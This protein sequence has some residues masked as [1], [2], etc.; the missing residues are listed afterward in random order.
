[1]KRFILFLIVAGLGQFG[2]LKVSG[3]NIIGNPEPDEKELS[4]LPFLEKKESFS[5]LI[6]NGK[7]WIMLAGELHNSSSSNI[8]NLE[9]I[10]DKMVSMNLNTVI[11][12]VSWELFEPVE[13]AFNYTLV[14]SII[15]KARE[16][17][18]KLVLI[19][20]GTWKNT[21]STYAPEWVKHDM[22]RFPRMQIIQG[23]NT[24][25]L[26]AFGENT[27]KADAAAFSAL[28]NHIREF[29]AKNQTVLMMQVENE[30]GVLGTTRDKS[31]LADSWFNKNIPEELSTYLK[32]NEK[33]L[34]PEIK[35]MVSSN[36]KLSGS[37]HEVFGY[38][39]D[40]V[41]QAWFT[42]RYVQKV[43]ESGKAA[44]NIPMYAN[45]WLDPDFS[46]SLKPNYPSGGPVMKVLDIWRAAAPD[47]DFLA[48][49]IYLDDFKRVCKM[50]AEAGNPLFIP[51][52]Q[53]DCRAAANVYYALGQHNAI[54]FSPFGI[55]GIENI[56]PV[57]DAYGSLKAL[58]PFFAE[59]QGVNK[60]IGLLYSG[61]KKEEFV[62]GGYK[63]IITYNQVRDI[64]KNQPEAAGLI[65]NTIEGEFFIAGFGFR[66]DFEQPEKK[67]WVEY[68]MHEEG[69]FKNGVW[70]PQRRMNGDELELILPS[71]PSVRKVKVHVVQ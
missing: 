42:A 36:K 55:D 20:F 48:P 64:E 31:V 4:V 13:G 70:K 51:E 39:A 54:C 1:M 68:L 53:R 60:N 18:L 25:A 17:N 32:K 15:L 52:A 16:H 47:I 33:N 12:T 21:W 19:W 50:Y 8:G 34:R 9:P 24:G 11:A 41:F 71:K 38:G 28:M 5:Q 2:T 22:K 44:Y 45:A 66:V 67:G 26:S 43:T 65:L 7:P 37:W 40:E 14:D 35:D 3:Q 62:L 63:I 49:D 58:L 46:T 10:W 61:Q 27:L 57:S 56:T 59:H 30:T 6:V 29:D 23:K 69:A